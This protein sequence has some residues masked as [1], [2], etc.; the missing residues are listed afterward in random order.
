MHTGTIASISRAA[1]QRTRAF[2][3][4]VEVGN[5]EGQLLPGMI[6]RVNVETGL[7]GLVIPQ[8]WVITINGERG[9]YLE[10]EG[11]VKWRPISLGSVIHNQVQ[12]QAGLAKGD[13]VVMVGHRNLIDGDKVLV[14]RTGA[15]CSDGRAQF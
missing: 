14:S 5:P 9:V 2:E 4:K 7:E 8:D 10:A 3:V 13:R 12:V 11:V 1:D 15:C 6:A